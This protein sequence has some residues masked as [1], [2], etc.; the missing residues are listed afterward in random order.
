M[1]R[2][3]CVN[4]KIVFKQIGKDICMHMHGWHL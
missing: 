4:N 1:Q 3:D 2:N